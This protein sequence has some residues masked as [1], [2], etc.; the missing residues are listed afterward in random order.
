[1]LNRGIVVAVI[2]FGLLIYPSLYS[3]D[4]NVIHI[5]PSDKFVATIAIPD[6]KPVAGSEGVKSGLFQEIIY[7]DLEISGYFTRVKNEQF[8][9][10]TNAADE[11]S[12]SINFQEWNRLGANFLLKS[13]FNLSGNTL[14]SECFFYDVKTNQRVFGKN[15]DGYTREQYRRMAHRIADEIIRYVSQEQG[16]AST[17]IAYISQIGKA[18]EVYIMDADGFGFMPLTRDG[19][20]AATP[21]WGLGA[22]EIY[23][24]SYKEY[25]PDLWLV[26]LTDGK[27]GVVSSHPGFNLSPAWCEKAQKMAL[28][29]SKDGNSEIYTMDH[30]GGNL[31]RLTYNK[32]IDASPSWSP[33]GNR[34]AFTSDR[35]GRPQIFVMDSEGLNVKKLT[36]QGSYNESPA[37]SPKGDRIAFVSRIEGRFHIF[38]MDTDGSNWVRLTT[39]NSNNEDPCW[40][41]DGRHIAFTSDRSGR[42]QIYVMN[43]DGSNI[44]QLTKE[45]TNQSPSWSP[46]MN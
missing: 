21:C 10:Q 18:K 5:R 34:I 28:T 31:K 2:L 11:K 39:G 1:M 14:S 27:A 43:D 9:A 15:F 12:G 4:P 37:W 23:Y 8:V 19:N 41:P 33:E 40:A 35:T 44:V 7:R 46:F 38:L 25:N 24:T 26:R 30:R 22:A 13:T 36:N 17:R 42:M 20:L 45:G 32:A 6:F 16:I 29:L 3:Q